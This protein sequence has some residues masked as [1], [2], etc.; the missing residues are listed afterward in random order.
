MAGKKVGE[1]GRT[2]RPE[3]YTGNR[4]EPDC[5]GFTHVLHLTPQKTGSLGEC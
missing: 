1:M 5:G 4:L 2:G 3:G